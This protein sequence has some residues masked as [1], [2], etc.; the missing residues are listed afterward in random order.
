MT[1]AK[2]LEGL[3]A[4]YPQSTHPQENAERD[5]LRT[6]KNMGFTPQQHAQLYDEL[7]ATCDFF[8]KVH[9]I[10]RCSK[11]LKFERAGLDAVSQT[12]KMLDSRDDGQ[13]VMSFHE[14]LYS[15]GY[16]TIVHDCEGD[17]LKVHKR[18]ALM[19]VTS[20]PE[21]PRPKEAQKFEFLT[22]NL[23]AFDFPF[24]PIDEL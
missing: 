22:D 14:W 3:K 21:R 23:P 12:R 1:P 6:V 2:I 15:G 4:N 10:Y 17:M 18:L 19:G 11:K 8:P 20:L 9:D 24:N 13:P 5:F 16:E 7:L